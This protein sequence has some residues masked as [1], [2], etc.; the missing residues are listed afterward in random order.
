M[1]FYGFS[2]QKRANPKMIRFK[3]F[4]LPYVAG[5]PGSFLAKYKK[6]RI[7][8]LVHLLQCLNGMKIKVLS[9]N[10]LKRKEDRGSVF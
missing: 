4:F 7:K 3:I 9:L 5:L 10:G 1:D 2:E 6:N 8:L